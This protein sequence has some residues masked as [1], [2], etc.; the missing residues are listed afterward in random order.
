MCEKG[1]TV[2][3]DVDKL[4]IFGGSPLFQTPRP[5]GQ[6][7]MPDVDEFLALVRRSYDTRSVAAGGENVLAL[8]REL[9]AYHGVRNCIT[10]ANAGLGL[11]MLLQ[12]FA[13]GRRG[14]VLMPAFT[15]RGLP[16]IARWAGQMPRFCEADLPTHTLDVGY[17]AATIDEKTTSILAVC[18]FNSAGDVDG[19]SRLAEQRGVPIVFDSVDA[20]GSTYRG[21]IL[22]GNGNAEAFST[23]ATKM[24]NGFEGGYIT[25]NDDDLADKLRWQRDHALT[26]GEPS[27]HGDVLGMNARFN[28]LHAA[29]SRL[30]LA[31]IGDVIARN[32]ARYEAYRA[33]CAELP[34]LELLECTDTGGE[35]SN[36]RMVVVGVGPE[37]PITRDET[38]AVLRAEGAAIAAYWHPALHLS[39][40]APPGIPVPRLPVAEALAERFLHLPV[41]ELVSLDDIRRIGERLELVARE[42]SAIAERLRKAVPA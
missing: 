30:S 21:R 26:E 16:H 39:S 29:M 36:Y 6:L 7:A 35:R 9:A 23:H 5:I 20:L 38:V 25:T 40:H 22:G 2:T 37:W 33:I 31:R 17:L 42:G 12:L 4:A 41:G 14:E 32:R 24:L 15:Y 11:I 8:E 10:V 3:S 28:E 27:E 18:N 1:T 19:L 34:G 13:N